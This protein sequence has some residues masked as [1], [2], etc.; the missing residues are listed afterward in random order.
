MVKKQNTGGGDKRPRVLRDTI[1]L[2]AGILSDVDNA[3]AFLTQST[4]DKIKAEYD[5]YLFIQSV[6]TDNSIVRKCVPFKELI[7]SSHKLPDCIY[8]DKDSLTLL[9]YKDSN[10]QFTVKKSDYNLDIP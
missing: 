5:D 7:E 4:L 2:N 10:S 1:T 6:D 3:S 9:G 8:L